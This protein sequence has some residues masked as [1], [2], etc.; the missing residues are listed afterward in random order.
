MKPIM[1]GCIDGEEWDDDFDETDDPTPL[2]R[3]S[4][5]VGQNDPCSCCSGK[6]SKKCCG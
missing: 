1:K 2:A 6:K 4:P 5:K 3:V